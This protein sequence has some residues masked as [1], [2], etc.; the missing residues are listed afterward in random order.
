MQYALQEGHGQPAWCLAPAAWRVLFRCHHGW[1]PTMAC[2]AGHDDRWRRPCSQLLEHLNRYN[3]HNRHNTFNIH[4]APAFL[5]SCMWILTCSQAR[6]TTAIPVHFI[7]SHAHRHCYM[8]NW[9]ISYVHLLWHLL[10]SIKYAIP[11]TS[12]ISGGIRNKSI[13]CAIL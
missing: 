6:L 9:L 11:H 2:H 3:D 7:H 8:P 13:K 4:A 5:H 12:T 10:I 1:L